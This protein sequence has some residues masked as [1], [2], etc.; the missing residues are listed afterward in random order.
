MRHLNNLSKECNIVQTLSAP[1]GDIVI[2]GGEYVCQILRCLL[3]TAGPGRLSIFG[4]L[5]PLMGNIRGAVGKNVRQLMTLP[6]L[7]D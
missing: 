1:E 2:A 3:Q 6:A 7:V 4:S 5:W